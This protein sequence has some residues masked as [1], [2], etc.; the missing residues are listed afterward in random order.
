MIALEVRYNVHLPS[1]DRQQQTVE[2]AACCR[3][4][5]KRPTEQNVLEVAEIISEA[6]RLVER[7]QSKEDV[8]LRIDVSPDPTPTR[9]DRIQL[10]QVLVN[11]LVN[12]GQGHG[13]SERTS[14]H[15]LACRPCRRRRAYRGCRGYRSEHRSQRLAATFEPF[16]TTKQDGLGWD[17]RSARPRWKL[18]A[19][20]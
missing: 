5:N 15:H 17:L 14:H 12:A 20:G 13:A 4:L 19:V 7:E 18:A 1:D 10:Q 9:G 3:E 11:L 8:S 6:V 2:H 16:F